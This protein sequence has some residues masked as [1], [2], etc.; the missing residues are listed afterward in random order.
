MCDYNLI[1]VRFK[2]KMQTE[3]GLLLRLTV[4]GDKVRPCDLCVRFITQ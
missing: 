2:Q 1:R 4:D 3:T